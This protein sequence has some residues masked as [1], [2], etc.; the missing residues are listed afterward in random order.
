MSKRSGLRTFALV[1]ATSLAFG[2][3]DF[4]DDFR[5]T[6]TPAPTSTRDPNAPPTPSCGVEGGLP[7][8][9][10]FTWAN[11]AP[12]NSSPSIFLGSTEKA[13]D[14]GN[15]G[16]NLNPGNPFTD[17]SFFL[18]AGTPDENGVAEVRLAPRGDDNPPVHVFAKL[19]VDALCIRIYPE[20]FSGELYCNGR[21]GQGV[22][23]MLTAPGGPYRRDLPRDEQLETSLG[24]SAPEGSMAVRFMFQQAR[25]AEGADASPKRC[26]EFPECP[27]ACPEFPE[28]PVGEFKNC[29]QP[30]QEGVF[31]T[32]TAFVLKGD[33][34]LQAPGNPLPPA[35]LTGEPFDCASWQVGDGPGRIVIPLTDYDDLLAKDTAAGLRLSDR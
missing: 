22:D 17:S 8:C 6:P 1:L 28:C 26:L 30:L 24:A 13:G 2:C 25:A 18:H 11:F 33:V 3:G 21:E 10:N 9:R 31:T 4:Q 14:P 12:G 16:A 32:G 7:G 35:G 19:L 34:D 29:Y 15:V 5:P 23:V 20:T 27:A